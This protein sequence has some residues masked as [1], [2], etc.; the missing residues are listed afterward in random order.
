MSSFN[1]SIFIFFWCSDLP[2]IRSSWLL[3]IVCTEYQGGS[4]SP[5]AKSAA[6]LPQHPH[7]SLSATFHNSPHKY[8]MKIQ[9]TI[10]YKNC[11]F[12]IAQAMPLLPADNRKKDHLSP[13]RWRSHLAVTLLQSSN[14]SGTKFNETNWKHLKLSSAFQCIGAFKHPHPPKSRRPTKKRHSI[15]M[16]AS[17]PL[18]AINAERNLLDH[19]QSHQK[20]RKKKVIVWF[21]K[22]K[23]CKTCLSFTM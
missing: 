3:S 1:N 15:P 6:P 13:N 12:H 20:V 9:N 2:L 19:T 22:T 4:G 8:K 17:F 23:H 5:S 14:Q 16:D 10:K 21:F 11:G 7:I 18:C